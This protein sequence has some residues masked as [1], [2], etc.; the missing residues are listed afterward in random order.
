MRGATRS[1]YCRNC[2]RRTPHT[3]N[4]PWN[5]WCCDDCLWP[6]REPNSS[7]W[8]AWLLLLVVAV[9]LA[10]AVASVFFGG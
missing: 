7:A 8:H 3:W 1:M 5:S 10:C 2:G 9:L 4:L 6:R